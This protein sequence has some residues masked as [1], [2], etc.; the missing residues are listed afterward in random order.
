MGLIDLLS[1]EPFQLSLILLVYLI[2]GSLIHIILL[3]LL[4]AL[5]QPVPLS[6][7]AYI[8]LRLLHFKPFN[9]I[10]TKELRRHPRAVLVMS[11]TSYWDFA[12]YVLYRLAYPDIFKSFYAVIAGRFFDNKLQARILRY[13]GGIPG[14]RTHNAKGDK[15][16]SVITEILKAKESFH[17]LIAPKGGI[18][19]LPWRSGYYYIAKGLNVPIGVVGV[20][21][22]FKCLW[23]S[24]VL[25]YLSNIEQD[26]IIL[27]M[28]MKNITPRNPEYEDIT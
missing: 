23:I 7:L 4:I 13:F 14:N 28:M 3:A 22:K 8:I 24:G 27:K 1:L 6:Y 10:Y 2:S 25:E 19:K 26:E 11:H 17:L 21:Y 18:T 16:V 9:M 5:L 20:D 15:L 12:M